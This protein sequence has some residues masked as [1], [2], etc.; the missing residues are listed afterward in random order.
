MS[1]QP[2]V[3]SAKF[4]KTITQIFNSEPP[5]KN[6]LSMIVSTLTM[7]HSRLDLNGAKESY[8]TP[9]PWSSLVE[10]GEGCIGPSGKL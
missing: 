3:M 6:A 10:G 8:L 1:F 2:M 4:Y 5:F 7:E 9:H